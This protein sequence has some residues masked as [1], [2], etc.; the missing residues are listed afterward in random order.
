MNQQFPEEIRDCISR[1]LNKRDLEIIKFQ[2]AMRQGL[3][4]TNLAFLFNNLFI[5]EEQVIIFCYFLLIPRQ[6]RK[7]LIIILFLQKEE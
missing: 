7:G 3:A 4:D 1:P 2:T 5:L 6:H